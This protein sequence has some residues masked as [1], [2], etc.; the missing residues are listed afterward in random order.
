MAQ[1]GYIQEI[2]NSRTNLLKYLEY[3]GYNIEE[4]NMFSINEIYAMFQNKQLDM[5]VERKTNPETGLP[6][7]KTYIKYHLAK[8]LRPTVIYD[9]LEDLFNL[10]QVL[11]KNDDLIIVA[12]DE[13]ND[14]IVKELRQIWATE[15]QFITIWHIKH[16][17]FNILEHSLVPKHRVLTKTQDDE[18]RKRYN[19]SSNSELP[20]IS[21]FDPVAMAIGIRPGQICEILRP[22]KTSITSKFY[23]ICSE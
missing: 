19:V 11:T 6:G 22:S 9:Y 4:Y 21:R 20:D 16:V 5:L 14:T 18:I 12:K 8:T 15:G 2:Y 10:E 23:R 1:S 13:P 17:Q 3:Q 7:K